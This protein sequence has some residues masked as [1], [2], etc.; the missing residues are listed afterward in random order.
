MPAPRTA[1]SRFSASD[2]DFNAADPRTYPDRLQVR[3]P[4]VSDYF[5]Q[6]K[7][8]GIVRAGQMEG[9]QPLHGEPRSSLRRSKW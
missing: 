7:E 8:V 3:V 1:R 4:G 5:V 2:R 6:G 9:E